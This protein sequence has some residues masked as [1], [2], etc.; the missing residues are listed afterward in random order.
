MTVQVLTRFNLIQKGQDVH[1]GQLTRS[2][3]AMTRRPLAED[4]PDPSIEDRRSTIDL[5]GDGLSI[6][7]SA[8][9]L[10]SPRTLVVYPCLNKIQSAVVSS[11]M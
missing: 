9:V 1:S 5:L 4:S 10:R 2:R 6:P 7:S 11:T 3:K 8:V